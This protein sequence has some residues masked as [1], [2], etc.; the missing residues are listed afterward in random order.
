MFYRSRL[1]AISRLIVSLVIIIVVLIGLVAYVYYNPS[2]S[3]STT[4]P[5]SS[6]VI[7][8]TQ[9]SQSFPSNA[10]NIVIQ[11]GLG[12]PELSDFS[13]QV[14]LI[15]LNVNSTVVWTNYD[16]IVHNVLTQ[17][18]P[19]GAA[20]GPN[21]GDIGPGQ[22]YSFTFTVAGNYSYY[23]SYHPWMQGEILVENS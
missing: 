5:S 10:V 4:L 14:V 1:R 22:S 21:S 9:S 3:T 12:Y 18:G 6:V 7:A 17:S 13:P 19:Y 11:N 16:S 2:T 8:T 23:C 15:V 20:G